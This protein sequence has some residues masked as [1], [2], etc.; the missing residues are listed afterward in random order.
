MIKYFNRK[1]KNYEIEKVA[2]E[3]YLE[4]SYSCPIGVTVLELIAKK[5]FFSNI[6]GFFCDTKL[7]TSKIDS[8]TKDFNIDMS[9]S[10]K[11][12]SDF[13]SFNDFFTRK[14]LNTARP[15]TDNRNILTSPGDGKALA[16]ENIDIDNLIQV[17]G[18][19]Y[20]LKELICDEA[21]AKKYAGGTCLVLRLCPTDYHRFHFIDDGICSPS[22]QIKGDYYSVNPIALNKIAQ[23]FCRNKREIS[24]FNSDNFGN[25]I[26]LE[27][28]ATG[29][30][31]IVQTY[32]ANERAYKGDEKGYFKFGGSTTILFFEPNTVK[33]DDDIITQTNMGFESAVL[34]GENIGFSI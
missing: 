9:I 33:I 12:I 3:K 4:W 5:K 19:T 7:S 16:Y 14:L 8:F 2:G 32:T 17:K 28:G 20:S 1:I 6:Y 26:I 23:I 25:V 15:I 24:L 21:L 34:M 13:S 29:V 30:G 27:V 10:Q 11:Q 18:Y 22:K 31:S